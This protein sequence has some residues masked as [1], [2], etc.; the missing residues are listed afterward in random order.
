MTTKKIPPWTGLILITLLVTA[1]GKSTENATT[2][3]S[4]TSLSPTNNVTHLPSFTPLP[5]DTPLPAPV[6]TRTMVP[7]LSAGDSRRRLLNLLANNDGCRLPCLWGI[8][9]G[10]S[11]FEEAQAILTPLSSLS[12]SVHLNSPGLGDISPRYAVEGD[13]EIYTRVAFL[14][15]PERNTVYRLA[16]NAEAHKP[17]AEGGYEDVF[18]S[19]FF[20][21]KVT[22]YSLPH[23]L[24]EE[25]IPSSVMIST[26]GALLTRGGR[27]GFDILLLY[28]DQGILVNYTTQMHLIGASVRGCPLNAHVEMELYPPG[29]SDLFFESLKQTDWEVKMRGYKPLEEVTSMSVEEF[30]K[31]FLESGIDCIE[32]PAMQWPTQEP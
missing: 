30:Y 6:I 13:L 27:G 2:P 17:L 25:G 7:T 14:T 12:H 28:P 4:E 24:S 10:E 29:R 31:T 1:C 8:S 19:K 22:A 3:L 5:T 23:I 9:P 20:G 18:D 21:E 26:Y 15:N 16:F 11:S 32:T